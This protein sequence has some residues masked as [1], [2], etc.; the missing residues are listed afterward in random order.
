[1][2]TGS[3]HAWRAQGPEEVVIVEPYVP[4]KVQLVI[5]CY[6]KQVVGSLVYDRCRSI[7]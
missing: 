2:V 1:M 7:S 6:N 4:S 5:E 3:G